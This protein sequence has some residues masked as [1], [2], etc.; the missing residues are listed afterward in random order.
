MPDTH[1]KMTKNKKNL[2]IVRAGNDSLHNFWLDIPYEERS[3]DLVISFFD[4]KAFKKQKKLPGVEKLYFEGGK[5]SGIYDA[6]TRTK[7]LNYNY[8]WCPDD[9]IFSSG[10]TISHL[11]ECMQRW[12]LQVAQ[13]SLTP[14]SFYS[15]IITMACPAFELRW[16]N[17]VEVM[18]PCF[19][20]QLLLDLLPIFQNR[21]TGYGLD[22]LWSLN[23]LCP[24][25]S[26]A[27]IDSVQMTHT[28][29]VG[30]VLADVVKNL[31]QDQ[32]TMLQLLLSE[33]GIENRSPQ[34][35]LGAINKGEIIEN[36]DILYLHMESSYRDHALN[37]QDPRHGLNKVQR[38]CKQPKK[39]YKA[40]SSVQ[41]PRLEFN[42]LVKVERAGI[43]DAEKSTNRSELNTSA[44]K[45]FLT[46]LKGS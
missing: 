46:K 41:I 24:P 34:V 18:M 19:S 37:F 42:H 7:E 27:V 38:L 5:W 14:A 16:T 39:K 15:H 28:R 4:K 9:D 17:F 2:I 10:K 22:Y 12:N 21:H 3:W 36:M 8:I 30:K 26:T 25:K 29:A 40:W 6:A 44:I 1:Q 20:K 35:V 43:V 11:F 32:K 23:G 45:K 31:G 13:P 33:F